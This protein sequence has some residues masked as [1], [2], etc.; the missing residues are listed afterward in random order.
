MDIQEVA[1][2]DGKARRTI[3]VSESTF[4]IDYNYVIDTYDNNEITKTGLLV[5]ANLHSKNRL[6]KKSI[7]FLFRWD[8]KANT[9]DIDPCHATSKERSK[10]I[11][12]TNGYSG[13]H[14]KKLTSATR[15]YEVE[16]IWEGKRLYHG[17]IGFGLARVV[18]SSTSLVINLSVSH[19]VN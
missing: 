9:L 18:V 15:E 4:Y 17:K 13:H 6:T 5:V 3:N 2:H 12:G 7:E 19:K 16:L 8:G 11:S 10:F 14:P 1:K